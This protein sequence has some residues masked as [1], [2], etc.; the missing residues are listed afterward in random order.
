MLH[1]TAYQYFII[2]VIDCPSGFVVPAIENFLQCSV[3][4]RCLGI[5]CC[6]CLDFKLS[7]LSLK[8][9]I[10]L[11]PCNFVISIGFEKLSFNQTLLSYEWDKLETFDISDFLLI[12]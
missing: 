3:N 11:D 1:L 4:D 2:M 6:V 7:K 8:T 12:R 10:I 5:E 9:W